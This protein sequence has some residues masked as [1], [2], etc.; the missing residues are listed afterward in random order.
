M[1]R[2]SLLVILSIICLLAGC[3][4]VEVSQNDLTGMDSVLEQLSAE[5]PGKLPEHIS[6]TLEEDIIVDADVC[7][8]QSLEEY[9]VNTFTLKRHLFDVDQVVEFWKNYEGEK[10]VVE[11]E[12]T[13]ANDVLEDGKERM[14][15]N[16]VYSDGTECSTREMHFFYRNEYLEKDHNVIM[17]ASELDTRNLK[18]TSK[19]DL[20]FKSMESVEEEA[21]SIVNR[22]GITDIME[23]CVKYSVSMEDL[24]NVFDSYGDQISNK[25]KE[26]GFEEEDKII[27]QN[28]EMYR[29]AFYQGYYGIPLIQYPVAGENTGT[30]YSEFIDP[31]ALSYGRQGM[32]SFSVGHVYDFHEEKDKIDILLLSQIFEKFYNKIKMSDLRGPEHRFIIKKISLQYLPKVENPEELL[33]RVTPVWCVQYVLEETQNGREAANRA[34]VYDAV[35]GAEYEGD[36]L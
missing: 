26:W 7:Y 19:K 18:Y 8:A 22:F 17:Y 30:F 28:D 34:V 20:D 1:K 13:V 16:V 35:T 6:E 3:M 24:Q 11:G 5:E 4:S 12:K 36:F 33:F 27:D 9:K 32:A 21:K 29:F 31:I 2:K 15:W 25:M 14:A 10:T 23:P